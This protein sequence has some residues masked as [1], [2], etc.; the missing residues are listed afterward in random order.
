MRG[1]ISLFVLV[2]NACFAFSAPRDASLRVTVA[3]LQQFLE[4]QRAAHVSDSDL[5]QK[6]AGVELSEQLTE[7][8][9]AKLK[10]E[11]MVGEKTATEL[12]L[13]ADMSAF[14]RPP[15]SEIA[16]DPPPAAAATR[17]MIRAAEDFCSCG[18]KRPSRFS[19]HADDADL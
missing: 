19:S 9:L 3:D 5:A 15:T 12:N 1:R 8:R 11:P 6:L 17:G 2:F 18:P 7:F 14:L 4:E 10:A 13:L 16:L